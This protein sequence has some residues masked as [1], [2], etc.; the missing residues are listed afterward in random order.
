MDR[1]FVKLTRS[2]IY[3]FVMFMLIIVLCSCIFFPEIT[4]EPFYRVTHTIGS[5]LGSLFTDF[6]RNPEIVLE[7]INPS[8]PILDSSTNISN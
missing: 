2:F 5:V 3:A 8:D 1:P 4:F 7:R 6:L